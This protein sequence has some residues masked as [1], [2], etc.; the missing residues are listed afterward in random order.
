M[1]HPFKMNTPT[2]QTDD[3]RDRPSAFE[4]GVHEYSPLT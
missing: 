1:K 3:S 4:F 2:L